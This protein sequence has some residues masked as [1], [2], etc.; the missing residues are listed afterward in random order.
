MH[1]SAL[2]FPSTVA[3]N[4]ANGG[5]IDATADSRSSSGL[6]RL[7]SRVLDSDDTDGAHVARR[8]VRWLESFWEQNRY[9]VFDT[10]M[11]VAFQFAWPVRVVI[12]VVPMVLVGSMIGRRV[13]GRR[14]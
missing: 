10:S 12:P 13:R 7:G 9:D 6:R 11:L 3:E 8:C 14:D 4:R 5:A 2:A 1:T